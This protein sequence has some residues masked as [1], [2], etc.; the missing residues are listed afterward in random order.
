MGLDW[1]PIGKPRPGFEGEF[2]ELFLRIAQLHR[3]D[4]AEEAVQKR[5]WEIS[6]SPY[7]TL[8]APCVGF[9]PKADEWARRK[10]PNRQ[11]K[12]LA[13]EEFLKGMRGYYVLDLVPKND[14]LPVYSNGY[15]ASYCEIFSFRAKFLEDCEDMLGKELLDEAYVH[16]KPEELGDYGRRLRDCAVEFAKRNGVSAILAQREPSGAREGPRRQA[17]I[18]ISAARWCL[19]WSERGHGMEADW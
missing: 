11:D 18:V 16:H 8:A 17:H 12:S 5:F 9:D 4:P 14:G 1:N 19:F 13:L 7:E 6:I 10:F 3:G 15:I 2:E